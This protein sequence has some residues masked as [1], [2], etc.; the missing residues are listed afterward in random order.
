M[1]DQLALRLETLVQGDIITP[2]EYLLLEEAAELM[3]K[4][5]GSPLTDNHGGMF[6]SHLAM[7]IHRTRQGEDV[8]CPADIGVQQLTSYP[9]YPA[10]C[11]LTADIL[12]LLGLSLPQGEVEY[13]HIHI[14]N[15][16]QKEKDHAAL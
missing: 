8:V 11:R 13:M 7:A 9:Q 12:A 5:C 1:E 4:H 6:L 2:E 14:C 16:L 10:A 3:E 15:L